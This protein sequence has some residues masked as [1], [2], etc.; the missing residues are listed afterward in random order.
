MLLLLAALCFAAVAVWGMHFVSMIS[1]RLRPVPNNTP[2]AQT[3]YLI[4]SHGNVLS[5][6]SSRPE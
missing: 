6:T 5:D 1:I 4:V 2:N 3:W